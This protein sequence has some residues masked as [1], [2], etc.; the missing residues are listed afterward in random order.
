[1]K[2]YFPLYGFFLIIS[3]SGCGDSDDSP[4]SPPTAVTLV[5]PEENSECTE[6]VVNASNPSTSTITFEWNASENTDT[7]QLS[8]RN[9]TT[10]NTET[11]TSNTPFMEVALERGVPYSWFVTSLNTSANESVNSNTWKFYNAGEGTINYPPFPADLL[12]PKSGATL[13]ESNNTIY[14]SWDATDIDNDISGFE[15][16]LGPNDPPT[17]SVA[18]NI[19]EESYTHSLLTTPGIYYWQIISTDSQGNSSISEVSQFKIE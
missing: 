14:F 17:I 1:M 19:T 2:K 6:G 4:P 9:L 5:F 16:L 18:T 10:N 8:I 12:E 7:Y 11:Y 15:L 13:Y 3:L